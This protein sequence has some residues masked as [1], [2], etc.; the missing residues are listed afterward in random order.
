LTLVQKNYA[1]V[2]LCSTLELDNLHLEALA[3]ISHN[4]LDKVA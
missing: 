1:G 3:E 2:M 4:A